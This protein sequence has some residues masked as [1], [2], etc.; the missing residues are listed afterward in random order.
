M[1]LVGWSA[2]LGTSWLQVSNTLAGA[3]ANANYFS[4][5]SFFGE[6]GIGWENPTTA[7]P[8]IGIMGSAANPGGQPILIASGMTLYELPIPEPATFALVGLGGLS[9]LLF[10]RRK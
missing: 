1:M 10:R 7:A 2:S 6:S 8:G 4:T 3:A 5:L 9:L